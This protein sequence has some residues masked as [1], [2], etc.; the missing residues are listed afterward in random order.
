M[1]HHHAT[2]DLGL[3]ALVA[4]Q[5]NGS[6]VPAVVAGLAL[7]GVGLAVIT[8]LRGK[9]LELASLPKFDEPEWVAD[10][11]PDFRALLKPSDYEG[12]GGTAVCSL[13]PDMLSVYQDWLLDRSEPEAQQAGTILALRTTDEP[14]IVTC[15]PGGG[16]ERIVCQNVELRGDDPVEGYRDLSR[17]DLLGFARAALSA[18]GHDAKALLPPSMPRQDVEI[19]TRGWFVDDEGD[20]VPDDPAPDDRPKVAVWAG[21]GR[22]DGRYGE[23]RLREDGQL[24]VPLMVDVVEDGVAGRL[25]VDELLS[26]R[27]YL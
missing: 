4:D 27:V 11:H 8:N 20:P 25:Y 5:G 14:F 17:D 9:P 16:T 18:T 12:Y 24:S 3:A 10:V 6:V 15:R 2:M 22:R 19:G 23:E 21:W 13:K 26:Y 7:A 1:G